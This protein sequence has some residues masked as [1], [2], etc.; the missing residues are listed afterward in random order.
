MIQLA[1]RVAKL[2]SN[3]LDALEED[4]TLA[5]SRLSEGPSRSRGAAARR[6]TTDLSAIRDDILKSYKTGVTIAPQTETT[7]LI[8]LYRAAKQ[9]LPPQIQVDHEGSRY[10]FY[11]VQ[12]IFGTTLP[13]DQY[14]L[15][16]EFTLK[17]E[18]DIADGARRTRPLSLFPARRDVDL[19]RADLNVD[20]DLDVSL[21]FSV[22]IPDGLPVTGKVD[23]GAKSTVSLGVGPFHFA[24]RK[25]LVEVSGEGSQDIL[26]RYQFDQRVTGAN[27]FKSLMVLKV[28]QEARRVKIAA[29]I[30]MTPCKA[31]WLVFKEVLPQIRDDVD[32][33][34][35]LVPSNGKSHGHPRG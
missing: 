34:V 12:I 35:E 33:P 10:D 1:P 29:A 23:A 26:W 21:N 27:D 30:A 31:H 18:D 7:P 15:A 8:P 11:L 9:A 25:A 5:S 24:V 19:F 3:A 2:D 16:A 17:L 14:P 13:S 22:P 4:L 28:A 6:A 32:L 20:V